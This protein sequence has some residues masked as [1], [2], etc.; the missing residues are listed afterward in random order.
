[1]AGVILGSKAVAGKFGY[2]IFGF[3]SPITAAVP[4]QLLTVFPIKPL[5]GA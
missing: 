3:C 4:Q 5:T 1:M 2:R